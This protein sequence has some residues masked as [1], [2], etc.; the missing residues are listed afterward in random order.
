MI[1][2][3]YWTSRELFLVWKK[4]TA[5]NDHWIEAARR[6]KVRHGV[7]VAKNGDEQPVEHSSEPKHH[8]Q[9]N[10]CDVVSVIFG[11]ENE[12]WQNDNFCA[13]HEH[14]RR[15]GDDVCKQKLGCGNAGHQSAIPDAL[16]TVSDE[17]CGCNER[18][19][20]ENHPERRFLV[21]VLENIQ[22]S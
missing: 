12:N 13:L 7:G 8:Q 20:E 19:K 10:D 4:L 1:K 11:V 2:S 18:G 15:L 14:D 6:H 17:D 22:K 5:K 21:N 3:F 16:E 9:N